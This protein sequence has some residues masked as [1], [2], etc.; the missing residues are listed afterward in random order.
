MSKNLKE[1][2]GVS[3]AEDLGKSIRGREK[4]QCAKDRSLQE[5]GT[6]ARSPVKGGGSSRPI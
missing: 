4:G 6:T 3:H 1:A 2:E 5:E